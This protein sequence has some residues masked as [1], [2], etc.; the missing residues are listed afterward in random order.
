LNPIIFTNISHSYSGVPVL[1]DISFEIEENIITAIIGRSGAG[2]STLLQMMNGLI[3]PL[4][5][6]IRIFG[7][8]IDYKKINELRLNIGYAVQ[9]TA[10]F[11]HMTV[12]DNISLLG[13]ISGKAKE[14]IGERVDVLMKLVDL[15]P[16][17]KTKY[18]YQLSGGEQQRVGLC[19]AILLNP[20]LFLLDEAFGALDPSTRQ[21]IHE[22]L[23]KL[24]K[25]EP[26]TIVLVTHDLQEAYN[27]G[28]RIMI[29][30]NGIIQQYGMKEDIANNPEN[31][32]VRQFVRTL[33]T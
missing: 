13:R 28:D 12:Y 8:K 31:D 6:E 24:Q 17:F 11:P 29:L 30:E 22:Q 16:A 2:K 4:S 21:E 32:F 15:D 26:R 10:L 18:P 19:R 23:L 25:F 7:S 33:R 9:G 3:A 27:L 1:D 20:K 5:G 14:E